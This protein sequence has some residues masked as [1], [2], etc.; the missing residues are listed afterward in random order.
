MDKTKTEID[1]QRREIIATVTNSIQ[2]KSLNS[3]APL[4]KE[5]ATEKTTITINKEVEKLGEPNSFKPIETKPAQAAT[6][7]TL[8]TQ[9]MKFPLKD[10]KLYKVSTFVPDSTH[11]YEILHYICERVEDNFN[12]TSIVTGYHP[13]IARLY[14]GMLF[15]YQ[16]L[17]AMN[18]AQILTFE[19]GQFLTHF[20]QQ[21]PPSSLPIAGPLMPIFQS[22]ACTEPSDPT[23]P[24][25]SPSMDEIIGPE[26]SDEEFYSNKKYTRIIPHNIG[27]YGLIQCIKYS[28]EE[29]P[30]FNTPTSITED[31]EF[32]ILGI[33]IGGEDHPWDQE[34]REFLI[35]PSLNRPL[36]TNEDLDIEFKSTID[37]Y[38]FTSETVQDDMTIIEYSMMNNINWINSALPSMKQLAEFTH[39]SGNLGQCSPKGPSASLLRLRPKRLTSSNAE[40]NIVHTLTTGFPGE[41]PYKKIYDARSFE[42]SM[43][44]AYHSLGLLSA[45]NTSYFHRDMNSWGSINTATSGRAGDYWDQHPD[46]IREREVDTFNSVKRVVLDSYMIDNP[47]NV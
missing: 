3:L 39:G 20:E 45:I 27:I 40:G 42:I 32:T 17:R 2:D 37:S 4:Q 28:G 25:V 44:P 11:M 14:Y 36:E 23:F 21:V 19:Q 7:Y 9:L 22:I 43:P 29:I 8:C 12:F 31:E 1:T 18:Q 10:V 33:T 35:N 47:F 34:T 24:L 41:M 6:R 46:N 15:Y 16:T 13:L 30:C 5:A 38:A 26:K